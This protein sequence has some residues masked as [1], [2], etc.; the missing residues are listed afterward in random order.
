[1]VRPPASSG[2]QP[3]T[4]YDSYGVAGQY[5]AA[6]NLQ[7]SDMTSLIG[8]NVAS[9]VFDIA[10]SIDRVTITVYQ[11]AAGEGILSWLTNVVD[12][13]I[14]SLGN[15][16]YF[17]YLAAVVI[18]GAIWLAWQGLIRK[19]GHPHHR[20]N[21]LDG[22]GL[23]GG[24]LADRQAGGLHRDGHGRVQ[25]HQPDAQHRVRQAPRPEPEQLPARVARRPAGP[26]GQL[27]LLVGQRDRRPERQR[28]VDRA[29]LQA[30]AG[31][32]VRHHRVRHL[33][34]RA[35]PGEHLR[36]AAAVGAGHRRQ[37]DADDRPDPGQAGHVLRASPRASSRRIPGST[38]C[39]RASSGRRGWRSRSP[40]CSPRRSRA[41]W[42]C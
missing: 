37:R 2:Q 33:G 10:K 40:R 25:R 41:F 21:H 14:S 3:A 19:R 24:D 9:M 12:K 38:R 39:S 20:G 8:N 11:S 26:A 4:L 23:R 29:G 32:R 36:Q 13:L 35:D 34:Q 16:I 31:R 22:G 1:M 30:L 18:I 27:Q 42:C 6:T 15:A 17:P 28:A 7:C 5:W